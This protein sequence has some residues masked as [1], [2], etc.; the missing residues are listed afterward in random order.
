MSTPFYVVRFRAPRK[1]SPPLLRQQL[2][3]A[4][5]TLP[6]NVIAI[7]NLFMFVA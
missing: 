7:D 2:G 5:H 4:S 1:I 6:T 3:P